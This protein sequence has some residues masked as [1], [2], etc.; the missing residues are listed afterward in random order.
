MPKL[1]AV[2]LAATIAAMIGLTLTKSEY[3]TAAARAEGFQP[4]SI[5][6]AFDPGSLQ[7]I[8]LVGP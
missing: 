1:S 4:L 8:P 7:S 3:A 5:H 2:A 6:M